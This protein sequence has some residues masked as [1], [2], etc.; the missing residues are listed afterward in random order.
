M[1]LNY[2]VNQINGP[3]ELSF[4]FQ[5]LSE[6]TILLLNFLRHSST[7]HFEPTLLFNPALF[8]L[9]NVAAD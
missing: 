7:A 4:L 6:R 3:E 8:H 1:V 2:T 9:V 5:K